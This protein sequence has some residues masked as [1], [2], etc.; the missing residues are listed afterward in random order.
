MNESDM[1]N[2]SET[3]WAMIDGLKDEQVDRSELPPL[4]DSFFDRASWRMPEKPISVTVQLDP[5]LLA[6]F[7]L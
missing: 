4:E 2:S 1:K 6:W 3:N 5:D 7:H